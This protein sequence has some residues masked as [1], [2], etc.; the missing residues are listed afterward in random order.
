MPILRF[1]E[2]VLADCTP[3]MLADRSLLFEVGTK[4]KTDLSWRIQNKRP[5]SP[6]PKPSAT[7]NKRL[8]VLDI[9]KEVTPKV[10]P[11]TKQVSPKTSIS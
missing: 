8:S 9:E 5:A 6:I 11:K 2:E 4:H 10:A 3:G 7:R 1:V